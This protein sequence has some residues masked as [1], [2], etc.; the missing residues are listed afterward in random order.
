MKSHRTWD[1]DRQGA[2][3]QSLKVR[4][5]LSPSCGPHPVGNRSGTALSRG[6]PEH[7][8][9]RALLALLAGAA[10]AAGGRLAYADHG[11]H[12]GGKHHKGA[13]ANGVVTSLTAT[14]FVVHRHGHGPTGF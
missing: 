6:V 7:M 13:V 1:T 4:G 2:E 3:A 11:G 14:G 12:G 10:L 9:R 5:P 8:N